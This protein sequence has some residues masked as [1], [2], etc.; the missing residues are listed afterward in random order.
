MLCIFQPR[1]IK[2]VVARWAPSIRDWAYRILP[3]V[4]RK[5]QSAGNKDRSG[6]NASIPSYH[7]PLIAQEQESCEISSTLHAL[8]GWRGYTASTGC[9]GR[10]ANNGAAG[11]SIFPRLD[12]HKSLFHW[13]TKCSGIVRKALCFVWWGEVPWFDLHQL[14]WDFGSRHVFESSGPEDPWVGRPRQSH[15]G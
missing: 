8:V 5:P 2:L 10:N 15:A 13:H 1:T 7:N 12:P 9:P 14:T 4:F 3:L 6:W 11:A